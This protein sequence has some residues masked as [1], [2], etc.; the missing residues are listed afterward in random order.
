VRRF[1]WIVLVSKGFEVAGFCGWYLVG[2]GGFALVVCCNWYAVGARERGIRNI[3]IW[4]GDGHGMK[5]ES[6]LL[7]SRLQMLMWRLY[8]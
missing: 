7:T 8:L 5:V 2:F 4:M 6:T 1:W 3:G